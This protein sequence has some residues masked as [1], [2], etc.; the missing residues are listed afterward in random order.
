[1]RGK[2]CFIPRDNVLFELGMFIGK[3]GRKRSFIVVPESR[4]NLHL[5]TDLSGIN[6][7]VY[8]SRRNDAN[9]EAALGPASTQIRDAIRKFVVTA[10]LKRVGFVGTAFFPDYAKR[11]EEILDQAREITLYFIHSRRWREDNHDRILR[12]IKKKKSKMLV[13]LP[14]LTNQNLIKNI[15]GHFDDGPYI[16]GFIADAYRYFVS[17]QNATQ[18]TVEIRLSQKYPTYSFYLFN[19]KTAIVAMYPTTTLRKSVPTF[20]IKIKGD[21][22]DFLSSDLKQLKIESRMVKSKELLS[23]ANRY[24]SAKTANRK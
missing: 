18:G 23:L 17:L 20:E 11:F 15:Q 9:W 12:F 8:D 4:S 10:P 7:L 6:P 5:P 1:M 24:V 16:P 22:G 21:Y 14:D 2:K 3:L 13:I 19:K